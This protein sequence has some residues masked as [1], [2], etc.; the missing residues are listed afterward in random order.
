MAR[1]AGSGLRW[2]T[3]L[4]LTGAVTAAEPPAQGTPSPREDGDAKKIK[5]AAMR[6]PSNPPAPA[7]AAELLD[8]LGRYADSGDGLDPLGLDDAGADG[9]DGHRKQQP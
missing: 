4:L 6:P 2:L 7:P 5:S 9:A 8:W 3:A 1:G